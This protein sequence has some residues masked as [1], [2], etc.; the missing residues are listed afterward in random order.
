MNVIVQGFRDFP[1]NQVSEQARVIVHRAA[2]RGVLTTW[3]NTR[4]A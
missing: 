3:E 2:I 4:A 1:G